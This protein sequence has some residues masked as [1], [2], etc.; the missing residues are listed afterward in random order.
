MTQNTSTDSEALPLF[1]DLDGTL[2]KTDLMFESVC[3]LLKRNPFN[4]VTMA[5]WLLKG[6][7]YL[8]ARLAERVDLRFSSWPFNEEFLDFLNDEKRTGRQLVLISAANERALKK[9]AKP[10]QLF[11]TC[12]GS[13]EQI[14]LKATAKRQRIEV[15]TR[16]KPFS[17]AGNSRADVSVWEAAAEVI[18]VNC[19]SSLARDLCD[20]KPSRD[21]DLRGSRVRYLW[22]AM[23]PHQWAKNGLL[24]IPLTLAHQISDAHRLLHT[25]IGFICFCLVASSVYLSNDL[26]DLESDRLH[27]TKKNETAGCRYPANSDRYG[28]GH[29]SAPG[30]VCTCPPADQRIRDNYF[31]ILDARRTLQRAAE[32]SFSSG[33]G[34]ARKLVLP[35]D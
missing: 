16:G 25:F 32:T 7:A 4:L 30:R 29:C 19:S 2:I 24:F 14:N 3:V 20:T 8:K 27:S 21:F 15:L 17:Y 1:V 31:G 12:V 22:Q 28:G 5:I 23:R 34:N 33:F 6:K 13:D 18:R 10:L 9:F 26:L 35:A 11:E